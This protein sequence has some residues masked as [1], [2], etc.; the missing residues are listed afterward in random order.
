MFNDI[1]QLLQP[2]VTMATKKSCNLIGATVYRRQAQVRVLQVTRPSLPGVGL[3]PRDYVHTHTHT[4]I[5][6]CTYIH[7]TGFH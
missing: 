4:C 1:V 6:T 2:R 3:A 7:L 5:C